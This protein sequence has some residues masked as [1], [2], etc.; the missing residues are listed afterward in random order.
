MTLAALAEKSDLTKSA[1][2]KIE[3][4]RTSSPV[5]TLARIADALSVP[6]VSFFPE[7][8]SSPQ[9][10]VT[11][12]GEGRVVSSKGS[13]FGY[14]YEALITQM[15]ERNIEPFVLTIDAQQSEERFHH[16][17]DEFAYILSG[18]VAF[19]VGDDCVELGPGD[20]IYFHAA[21]PHVAK[22]LGKR[23]AKM[24]VVFVSNE[25]RRG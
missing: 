13:R 23:P 18:K 22:S 1:L 9:Y 12:S 17:G 3:L 20:V 4:G 16:D 19:H 25:S 21:T 15:R 5:S 7:Q 6:L 24:L 8:A 14:S 10:A 11:R 2:S